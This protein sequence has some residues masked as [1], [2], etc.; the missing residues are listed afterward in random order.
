MKSFVM[1]PAGILE[2]IPMEFIDGEGW[3]VVIEGTQ[4]PQVHICAEYPPTVGSDGRAFEMCVHSWM[5]AR[6]FGEFHQ[7]FSIGQEFGED[8]MSFVLLVW[9]EKELE[10]M[11]EFLYRAGLADKGSIPLREKKFCLPV[12]LHDLQI[13]LF[14]QVNNGAC[15]DEVV[16]LRKPDLG[17]CGQ[18]IH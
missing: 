15:D 6:E 10:K 12:I 18:V 9:E 14:E 5:E 1:S 8:Q 13:E 3:R 2:G 16:L 11:L 4:L 17:F 7:V